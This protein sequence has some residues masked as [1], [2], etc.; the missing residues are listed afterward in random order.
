M[1]LMDACIYD[2]YARAL[3]TYDTALSRARHPDRMT[4]HTG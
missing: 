2:L 4:K 3:I 1:N